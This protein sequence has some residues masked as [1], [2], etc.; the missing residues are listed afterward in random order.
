MKI[1]TFGSDSAGPKGS[2][3]VTQPASDATKKRGIA[4]ASLKKGA[5]DVAVYADSEEIWDRAFGSLSNE[6][7]SYVINQLVG[8]LHS[9]GAEDCTSTL[10]ALMAQM[11]GIAPTN[12]M[13]AMLAVQMIC[14]HHA[15]V[16][17]TRRCLSADTLDTLNAYGTLANKFSRTYAAQ[18]EGLA[19]LRRGGEQVV[20][21][22]H[23]N[24]GGQAVI[25]ATVNAGRGV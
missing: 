23:V 10:N 17:L 19:K 9:T 22:V 1:D 14:A 12:E 25:A 18:M 3:V 13:E 11:S 7:R 16:L 15:S 6:F 24:E 20:K 4:S 8:I 5:L 21:H 2:D